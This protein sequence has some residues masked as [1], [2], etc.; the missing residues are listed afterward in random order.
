MELNLVCNVVVL[1]ERLHAFDGIAQTI[2]HQYDVRPDPATAELS[3]SGEEAVV[4]FVITPTGNHYQVG[5]LSDTRQRAKN[6]VIHPP[7]CPNLTR[8]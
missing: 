8:D 6:L 2:A 1:G 4:P 3:H 5:I 7:V